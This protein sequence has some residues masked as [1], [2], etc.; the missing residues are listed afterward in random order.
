MSKTNNFFAISGSTATTVNS[1]SLVGGQALLVALF[2]NEED[3]P[4]MRTLQ[5]LVK[6]RDI[7]SLKIRGKRFFSPEAVRRALD[8]FEVPANK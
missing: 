1:T 2:P 3:R 8:D 4:S 6:A 7:P 5:R